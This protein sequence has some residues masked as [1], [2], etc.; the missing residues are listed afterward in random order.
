MER[1]VL[2]EKYQDN[3][4]CQWA[5]RGAVAGVAAD[6]V[7]N[8]ANTSKATSGIDFFTGLALMRCAGM[9]AAHITSYFVGLL[10]VGLVVFLLVWRIISSS[11]SFVNCKICINTERQ[12]NNDLQKA[13]MLCTEHRQGTPEECKNAG[14]LVKTI[15]G[16]VI[17]SVIVSL[18]HFF[19]RFALKAKIFK[20]TAL[21]AGS[22]VRAVV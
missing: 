11:K 16:L 14:R 2:R 21:F 1:L 4:S 8:F 20:P 5:A 3:E 18:L 17:A 22:F 6:V 15:L 7:E 9:S 12:Y 19:V 13:R 10:V